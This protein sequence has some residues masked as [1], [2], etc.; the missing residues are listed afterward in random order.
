MK[1]RITITAR[2]TDGLLEIWVNEAGRDL[3]VEGLQS[4]NEK[5]DHFHLGTE[6]TAMDVPVQTI[7][8]R[9]GDVAHARGKV[10]FRPDKWDAEYF[11]HVLTLKDP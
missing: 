6:E 7:P 10:L 9:D 2:H 4:L 5:W 3:L 1:P 8:Y 11:P